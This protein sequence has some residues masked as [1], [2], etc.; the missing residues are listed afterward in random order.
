MITES[1]FHDKTDFDNYC[2]KVQEGLNNLTHA[3]LWCSINSEMYGK[4]SKI[5][6]EIHEI[7]PK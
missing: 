3:R 1:Q 2:A 4:L 5:I 6:A 7:N